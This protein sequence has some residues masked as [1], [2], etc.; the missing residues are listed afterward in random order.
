LRENSPK[1]IFSEILLESNFGIATV[2]DGLM[3]SSFWKPQNRP[4]FTWFACSS[5]LSASF[6]STGHK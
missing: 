6:A 4:F 3:N 2:D 1:Q 5:K